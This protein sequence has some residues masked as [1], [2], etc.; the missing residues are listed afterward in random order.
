MSPPFSKSPTPSSSIE[1]QANKS[2]VNSHS[3]KSNHDAPTGASRSYRAFSRSRCG[4]LGSGNASSTNTSGEWW[5]VGPVDRDYRALQTMLDTLVD[6]G[7]IDKEPENKSGESAM[8]KIKK[9]VIDEEL[10][11]GE[12]RDDDDDSQACPL[13]LFL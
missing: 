1:E 7:V 13:K 4:E 9:E 10:E 11:P 2:H 5:A 8:I 6:F 12:I 3:K